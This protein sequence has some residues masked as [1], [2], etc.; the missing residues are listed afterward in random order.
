MELPATA[1]PPRLIE[2]GVSLRNL[3]KYRQSVLTEDVEAYSMSVVS[4]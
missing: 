1:I 3:M 4:T 2:V